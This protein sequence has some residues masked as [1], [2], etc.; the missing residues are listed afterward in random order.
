MVTHAAS[1]PVPNSELLAPPAG[2]L[3]SAQ[4]EVAPVRQNVTPT[5]VSCESSAHW[6]KF[7]AKR[8]DTLKGAT[9]APLACRYTI[10]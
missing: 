3:V 1:A 10:A 2:G 9:P 8:L 7:Q 6:E 5:R 4:G